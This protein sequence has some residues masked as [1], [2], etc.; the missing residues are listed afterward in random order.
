MTMSSTKTQILIFGKTLKRKL[1]I[2]LRTTILPVKEDTRH[3]LGL[4]TQFLQTYKHIPG[5]GKDRT[6]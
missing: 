5:K 3:H 6:Q 2:K 4:E 1:I